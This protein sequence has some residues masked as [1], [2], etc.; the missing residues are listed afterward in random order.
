MDHVSYGGPRTIHRLIYRSIHRSILSRVSVDTQSSTGRYIIPVST[1]SP[2]ND[3][4]GVGQH[5]DRDTVSGISVNY[6]LYISRLLVKY[7]SILD[8]LSTCAR[9]SIDRYSAEY[10]PMYRSRPPI[11]YMI[12]FCKVTY[13]HR[14]EQ[15][16]KTWG[17][18]EKSLPSGTS[19]SFVICH[20]LNKLL[21]I[22]TM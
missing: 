15:S 16:F 7:W 12:P 19:M 8:R 20:D 2:L 10:R 18:L 4:H 17:V 9:S 1:N 5:I 21:F 11:R 3:T 14:S 6:W 22:L 13:R